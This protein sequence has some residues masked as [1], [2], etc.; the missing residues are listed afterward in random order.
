VLVG[1]DLPKMFQIIKLKDLNCTLAADI[2]K[3]KITSIQAELGHKIS[4]A[5]VVNALAQGFKAILKI[6]LLESELTA[7][8]KAAAE[9]LCKEKYTSKEWNLSANT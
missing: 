3:R 4:P 1:V 9:T 8:E 7:A 6:Q 2:G 5:T